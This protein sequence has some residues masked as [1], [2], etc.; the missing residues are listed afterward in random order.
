MGNYS[1]VQRLGCV[2]QLEKAHYSEKYFL[3]V[4]TKSCLEIVA[5]GFV[6]FPAMSCLLCD[7]ELMEWFTQAL[8]VSQGCSLSKGVPASCPGWS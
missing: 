8:C 2:A 5:M 7:L 6:L 1:T 3:S 4:L